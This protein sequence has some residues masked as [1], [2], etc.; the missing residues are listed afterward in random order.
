MFVLL[1][2]G[3]GFFSPCCELTSCLKY[4]RNLLNQYIPLKPLLLQYQSWHTT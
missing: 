4:T 2:T 3:G 1:Q